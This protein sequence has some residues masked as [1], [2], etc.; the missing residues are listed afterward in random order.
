MVVPILTTLLLLLL[1]SFTVWQGE[2]PHTWNGSL[3][4]W[5]YSFQERLN[6]SSYVLIPILSER[7]L[8]APRYI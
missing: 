2:A 7:V 6:S 3:G 4:S 5:L 8:L 1:T